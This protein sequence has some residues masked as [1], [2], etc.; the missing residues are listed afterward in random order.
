MEN[1]ININNC[2]EVQYGVPFKV[3]NSDHIFM[4]A[5]SSQGFEDIVVDLTLAEYINFFDF[6]IEC[7]YEFFEHDSEDDEKCDYYGVKLV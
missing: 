7:G 6:L 1:I 5:K 3:K 4:I 2:D